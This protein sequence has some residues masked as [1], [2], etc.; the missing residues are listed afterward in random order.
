MN[1]FRF[2][3]VVGVI[4]GRASAADPPAPLSSEAATALASFQIK[5]GFRIQL[6][7]AEPM[8]AAPVAMAF[9]EDGRLFV[10]EMRDYPDSRG[11]TPHLGRVRLLEDSDGDGVFDSSGVY[12]ENLA[13]PSAIACFG[14][15]VFVAAA[16][17]IIYLKDSRKDGVADIRRVALQ[18]FGGDGG[19]L[20]L[21]YLPNS[22]N[23]S[24]DNR[25]HAASAGIG[26]IVSSTKGVSAPFNL[27][28]YDFSFDPREFNL[29]LE[30]GPAQS[31]LTFDSQGCRFISDFARPARLPQYNPRYI[32]RNPF[33]AKAP[34]TVDVAGAAMPI[35]RYSP[36][37]M[38]GRARRA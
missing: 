6:V 4:L 30:A 7:A 3:C 34:E 13:W 31:G 32:W 22:F 8:V 9:D 10:A 5:T 15:G 26:G 11:E 20:K 1:V 14:G 38:A 18:G 28:R 25:I 17:E 19:A 35:F 36:A 24:M 33:F 12:A 2:L 21:D 27:G 37:Q 29:Q 16:P 23:W